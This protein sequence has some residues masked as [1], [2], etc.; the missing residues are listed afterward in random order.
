[1]EE[2]SEEGRENLVFEKEKIEE[3]KTEEGEGEKKRREGSK[4]EMERK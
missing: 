1:M 2:G 3:S 4:G